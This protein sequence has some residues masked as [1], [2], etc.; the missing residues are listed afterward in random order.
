MAVALI[1]AA[2]L[3]IPAPEQEELVLIPVRID[4]NQRG[5]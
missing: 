2:I 3:P 4:E 1:G 5:I